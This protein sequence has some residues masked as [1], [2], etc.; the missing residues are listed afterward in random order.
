MEFFRPAVGVLNRDNVGLVLLLRPVLSEEAPDGLN[1][2]NL[3]VANTH[4]LYNP[5]RGD[6]KL[7]QLALLLAEVDKLSH[8]PEGQRCPIILCGDLNA[9]PSSPLYQ[10]LHNGFLNCRSVPAWKVGV[11]IADG[12]WPFSLFHLTVA[13]SPRCLARINTG[14]FHSPGFCLFLCCRT[15]WGSM[16]DAGMWRRSHQWSK[17]RS[18]ILTLSHL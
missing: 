12:D 5:R 2:P 11:G 3:C 10:L 14:E 17:V 4:L 13:F 1:P 18:L 7:A 15:F 16:T 9:T 6:I 8:T